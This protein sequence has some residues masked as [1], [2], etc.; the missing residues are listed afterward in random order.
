MC[1][2][3]FATVRNLLLLSTVS[4]YDLVDLFL[5]SNAFYLAPIYSVADIVFVSWVSNCFLGAKCA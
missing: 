3:M 2:S 4:N 5:F 1:L